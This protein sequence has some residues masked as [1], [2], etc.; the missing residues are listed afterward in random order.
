MKK[1]LWDSQLSVFTLT[2]EDS[3][4]FLHGQTT[5]N[6]INAPKG[7]FFHSC[8]LTPVGKLKALLEIKVSD[9]N[10]SFVLLAGDKNEVLDGLEKVIFI[11]DKVEIILSNKIRRI[12]VVNF[13]KSWKETQPKWLPLNSNF[14]PDLDNYTILNNEQIMEWKIRQGLPSSLYEVDGK[15]NPLELGLLDL[16]DFD[17]GC[18]LGQE[19]IA[20][21]KNIGRLKY[22]LKFFI[23]E[24]FFHPG[25]DLF[26]KA[27]NEKGFERIGI[28]TSS[29]RKE[30]SFI[31]LALIRTKFLSFDNIDVYDNMGKISLSDPIG[32]ENI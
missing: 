19:T 13:D 14:T 26:N 15:N 29:M 16:I 12:Q 31:G 24:N 27:D 6:V 20:K 21:V 5:A 28:V 11:S 32:F 9:E 4:K 25:E 10:V 1:F 17:K 2:G 7:E 30:D 3:R 18:Y 8:W 23:S 22:Q